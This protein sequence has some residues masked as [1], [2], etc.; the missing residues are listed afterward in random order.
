M[1]EVS[2]GGKMYLT[3]KQKRIYQFIKEY[4][5]HYGIAPSY[6]EI[7][8][9]FGLK[10]T[11]TVFDHIRT[12]EKKGYIARGG[13]NQKRSLQLINFGKRSVTI[14]LVGTVAAGRPLEVY[15]IQE[16]IDVPEEMLGRGENVALKIRGDSMVDSGIYDGDIVIVKRQNTAENGQIAVALVDGEATIKRVYFHK[17]GVELRASNPSVV[18]IFVTEKQDLQI[19]GILVGLYRTFNL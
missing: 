6:E 8:T 17:D 5:S 9:H 11:S 2:Q 16:Y 10:S 14:P 1:P 18:S 3:E 19:F 13:T 12:L 15:E 7:R 4:I